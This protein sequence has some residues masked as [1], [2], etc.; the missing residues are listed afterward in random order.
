MKK[1]RKMNDV[2]KDDKS[3]EDETMSEEVKKK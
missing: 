1:T 2:S 3:S